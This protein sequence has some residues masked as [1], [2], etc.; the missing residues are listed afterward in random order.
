MN[1]L[2]QFDGSIDQSGK[3]LLLDHYMGV[4]DA[5]WRTTLHREI[6]KRNPNLKLYVSSIGNY[7]KSIYKNN[8]YID[9]LVDRIGNPPYADDVNYYISVS[10][11]PSCNF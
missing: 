3:T 5:L 8:P 7:W 4:G 2:K 6:K 1:L 11:M 9:K 10:K